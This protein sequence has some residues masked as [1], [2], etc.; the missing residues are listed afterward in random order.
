[1]EG[2]ERGGGTRKTSRFLFVYFGCVWTR[3]CRRAGG[4]VRHLDAN[5]LAFL[6]YAIYGYSILHMYIFSSNIPILV[7]FTRSTSILIPGSN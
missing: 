5:E 3:V 6:G 4:V 7:L 2:W 1:M